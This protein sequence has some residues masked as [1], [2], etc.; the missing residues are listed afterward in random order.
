METPRNPVT[1]I[2]EDLKL[3]RREFCQASG[4]RPDG[5]S[6]AEAGLIARPQEKILQLLVE[7]GYDT[8]QVIA[9]YDTYREAI[10]HGTLQEARLAAGARRA[11]R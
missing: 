3:T 9:R 11:C 2:R 5:L 1:V 10:R 8:D 6:L 4:I 7:L